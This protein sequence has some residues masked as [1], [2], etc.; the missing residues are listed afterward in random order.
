MKYRQIAFSLALFSLAFTICADS[1][2]AQR[3]GDCRFPVLYEDDGFRGGSLVLQSPV[4]DL[5]DRGFGDDASSLCVPRGWRVIVYEDTNFRGDA[6]EL[7]GPDSISDLKR[8]RPGGRDWGDRISSAQVYPPRRRGGGNPPP[9]CDRTAMLFGNDD[10]GGRR[11]TL[12]DSIPDLHRLGVGDQASSLCVPS[13]WR[14]TIFEDTGYRGDRL[15]VDGPDSIADLR[16]DRPGGRSWGDR[17]SSVRV[18]SSFRRDR[19]VDRRPIDPIDPPGRCDRFPQLF[20]EDDYRGRSYTLRDSVRDL[21]DFRFGRNASSLCVPTGW[22]VTFFED[23]D[24]RGRSFQVRG[25]SDIDDLRRTRWGNW[26]NRISS[27]RIGIGVSPREPGRVVDP[28]RGGIPCDRYPVLYR[29]D[30]FRGRP[31]ELRQS[32]P[33]LHRQGLGDEASSICVPRGWEAILF[34]DT[35]YRGNS[36]RVVGPDS[37]ADLDRERRRGGDWGDSASSV[38][39]R[40]RR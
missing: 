3:R 33:D 18:E 12:N 34:E 13:G 32:I 14:I 28:G 21:Y 10:F 4:A 27:A 25:P 29:N 20:A 35:N 40:R 8:Q 24:Y 19:P 17:I 23:A 22:T 36:L 1:A 15:V 26:D 30:D 6:L 39:V 2:W 16:R 5:H 37:I 9:E 11:V 31:L 7:S 38:Q